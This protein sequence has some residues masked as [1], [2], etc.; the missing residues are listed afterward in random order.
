MES[1]Y[2]SWDVAGWIK[3]ARQEKREIEVS[4]V[5]LLFRLAGEE[6]VCDNHG[7]GDSVASDGSDSDGTIGNAA[8]K[9][10]S[11]VEVEE[12]QFIAPRQVTT[13]R[14][15][16]DTA[17]N[18][19]LAPNQIEVESI[20]SLISSGTELKIFNG[21]FDS[22]SQLDVNI[23]G[24]DSSMKYPLA[25]GYSL[26]GRVVAC[27]SDVEDA[28][29]LTGR[30]VFAFSPHSSRIVTDRDAVKLVPE[31]I[32]AED[33]IFLPSVETALS[34]VHDAHV[35]FGENVAVFGQGLIGLLVTAVLSLQTSPPSSPLDGFFGTVTAFDALEDRL[36]V[37]I[38][39]GASAALDP[40]A[41][42]AAGPFDVAIEASGNPR[43]L[44]A[45]IDRTSDGG[46]VIVAS[47][48]GQQEVSLKL[49][50]NFHRSHKTIR[51]SQ[52]STMP[53]EL[54]GLWSKERRFSLA[55]ALV[56]AIK[57]SKLI[58]KRLRLDE[59]QLA[60][61]LLDGGKEIAV[62]FEYNKNLPR[63]TF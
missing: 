35:R 10:T 47:W 61:E 7:D 9:D 41:T 22:E 49:G 51:T 32:S 59:A 14:K 56:E 40:T 8:V 45:A 50:I 48:Y 60:Y 58:S 27:G 11:V 6:E 29:D 63:S 12:I 17:K 23:K 5:D 43:A 33:A 26:V 55:W 20:C 34:I 19:H 1:R 57:P 30:L 36:R 3:R 44:Q 21:S 37:A 42:A 39:M 18:Q 13:N 38:E 2:S 4:N 53:A 16:W 28:D 62:C 31:G 54:T 52:V 25:Y 46:R 15:V 24:M